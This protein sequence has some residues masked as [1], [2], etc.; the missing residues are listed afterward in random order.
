MNDEKNK[1]LINK[2]QP[3]IKLFTQVIDNKTIYEINIVQ[4]NSSTEPPDRA[5]SG[6]FRE[7]IRHYANNIYT[8]DVSTL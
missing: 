3:M 7:V 2:E 5:A 8:N 6:G 4:P 1:Q